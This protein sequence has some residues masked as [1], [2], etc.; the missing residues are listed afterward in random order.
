MPTL[1]N[2]MMREIIL[3]HYSNPQ[4]KKTPSNIDDYLNIHMESDNC[5]D[6]VHIYVKEKDNIIIDCLWDGVACTITTASCDIMCDLVK[7]LN[8]KQALNIIENY[9]NMIYEKPYDEELLQEANAFK[10]TSKQA[11]RIRCAT[12]GFNGLK[13]IILNE[14][15]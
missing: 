13:E 3:D 10:N 9:F 15:K 14:N 5:I 4:S 1:T 6:D 7:G 11:A 8:K 12:I 2:E